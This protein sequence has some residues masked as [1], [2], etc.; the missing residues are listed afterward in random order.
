[1]KIHR[2]KC[3]E[4][5]YTI[6]R[7]YGISP[8]KLAEQNGLC[9]RGSLPLGRE[10]LIKIPHRTYNVRTKDTL[11]GIAKRFGTTVNSLLRQNPELRGCEGLYNGQLLSVKDG[12]G[13]YG[14]I[15]TNGYC[16]RGCKR[17]RLKAI[18]PY[19]SYVTFCSSV[20]KDGGIHSTLD[21]RAEMADARTA[22]KQVLM[23]VYLTR[24]PETAEFKDFAD[25]MAILTR[26]GGY[27][28]AVLSSLSDMRRSAEEKAELVIAVRRAMMEND[29][30]LFAEGDID[31]DCKYTEYADAAI[32][33]YD[34]LHKKDIPTFTDG[35]RRV[36]TD[37]AEKH[38]SMRA[39]IDIPC[40]ALSGRRYIEKGEAIRITDRRRGELSVDEERKICTATYGR[41]QKHSIMY[42]SLENTRSRLELVSELGYM[43]VS[44]D[45]G[46]I[47]MADLMLIS[48]MYS[49]IE[50]PLPAYPPDIK[51]NC[52]GESEPTAE[53]TSGK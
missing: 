30:T 9:T 4:D 25:G 28:G 35:E 8:I 14:A 19:L 34:K 46:R 52:R 38:D 36:M 3:G 32:L 29:L 53:D 31:K 2:V 20:Y 50:S 51:I 49:V 43:G 12:S 21:T 33:I 26:T 41:G 45:I 40:F 23:R 44:L 17:E 15:S 18:L 11:A 7:E 39:F 47:C 10:L 24:M 48:E 6:A 1:M 22:G 37:Y 42:E 16:Y 13:T 5:I 27:D